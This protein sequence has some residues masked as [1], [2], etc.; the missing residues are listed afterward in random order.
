MPPDQEA[1]AC[2]A[3]RAEDAALQGTVG[4]A[5]APLYV[6]CVESMRSV[7]NIYQQLS[8]SCKLSF[9]TQALPC[10]A[11][12]L[13]AKSLIF[14]YYVFSTVSLCCICCLNDVVARRSVSRSPSRSRSPRSKS[15]SVS[16]AS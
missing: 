16:P 12:L 4:F 1:A 6:Q 9:Q 3:A 2:H 14:A 10:V 13:L 7:L 8:A 11:M 5:H 15:R